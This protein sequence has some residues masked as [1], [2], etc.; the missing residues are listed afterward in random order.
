[1]INAVFL[2]VVGL[3]VLLLVPPLLLAFA[4]RAFGPP[5][6]RPAPRPQPRLAALPGISSGG[7]N[8]S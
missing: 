8:V 4:L 7:R 5:R 1:M 6:A 3:A 2:G